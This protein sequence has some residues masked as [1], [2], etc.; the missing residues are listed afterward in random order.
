[1]RRPPPRGSRHQ[2]PGRL[3]RQLVRAWWA[4]AIG[5][6]P[7]LVLRSVLHRMGLRFRVDARPLPELARR[8]DIVFRR[9]KVAV[10]VNG[11]FWH[12]CPEHASWPKS[13]AAWWRSKIEGNRE[14]DHDTDERLR[15]AGWHPVQVWEHDNPDVIA[16]V[17]ARLVKDRLQD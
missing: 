16:R 10:F 13:N 12:A 3:R 2:A 1:M 9:V 4:I 7:E 11:C 17:I 5:T 15:E 8:A 14:R 6:T